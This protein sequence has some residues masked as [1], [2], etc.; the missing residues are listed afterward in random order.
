MTSPSGILCA[1][2][3]RSNVCEEPDA[4]ALRSASDSPKARYGLRSVAPSS[5]CCCHCAWLARKSRAGAANDVSL[6]R[7][8]TKTCSSVL[9]ALASPWVV[10]VI[11]ALFSDTHWVAIW[12]CTRCCSASRAFSSAC[13]RWA[14]ASHFALWA[15]SSI[16]C[17]LAAATS[18]RLSWMAWASAASR[19]RSSSHVIVCSVLEMWVQRIG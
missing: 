15:G 11:D 17:A 18:L 10:K 8:E 16:A 1:R 7:F 5:L 6:L 19:L 3:G 14:C 13:S 12:V 9:A 2:S 4:K